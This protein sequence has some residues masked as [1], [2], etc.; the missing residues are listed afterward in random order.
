[1]NKGERTAKN[2]LEATKPETDR[3]QGCVVCAYGPLA[4]DAM[5]PSFLA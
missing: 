3:D 4:V 2:W 1:M 5:Q